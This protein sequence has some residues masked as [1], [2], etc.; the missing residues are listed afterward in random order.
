VERVRVDAAGKLTVTSANANSQ[1][2][3]FR[4]SNSESGAAVDIL[5]TGTTFSAAAWPV[6][7]QD[8]VVIRSGAAASGGLVLMGGAAGSATRICRE[9]G[10]E[11]ARFNVAG[12][13]IT[14]LLTG[15][16][17]TQS[18][19]DVT[20]NR[21]LRTGAGPS[22]AYRQ[23]NILGPVSQSG[24][25]PTGRV[26]EGNASTASPTGGWTERLA[27][28][29]QTV[30]HTLTSSASADTTWTYNSAFLAGS[31]PIISLQAIGDTSY[32]ARVVSRNATSCV[33]SIRDGAGNRVAV[34]V[35]AIAR[36][37]WSNMT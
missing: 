33:F 11:V 1:A 8:A 21:L 31:T 27:D 17:V 22:Q 26:M 3:G 10:A 6:N 9:D 30:H 32:T 36:G 5:A 12:A 16:A 2:D 34:P 4:V 24:G 25:V 23:G 14:G 28:G 18:D 7:A 15:T 19:T 35:D 29:F 37:R 20:A 13:Q